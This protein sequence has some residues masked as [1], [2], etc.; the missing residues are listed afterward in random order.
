MISHH[1]V[2]CKKRSEVAPVVDQTQITT[3]IGPSKL[4]YDPA[5]NKDILNAAVECCCED[6]RPTEMFA[7]NGFKHLFQRILQAQATFNKSSRV[8]DASC[9]LS[10]PSTISR[11]ITDKYNYVLKDVRAMINKV[12]EDGSGMPLQPIIGPMPLSNNINKLNNFALL[13][14]R[15]NSYM[16]ITFHC[17]TEENAVSSK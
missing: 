5:L 16:A 12:Y 15:Q 1:N 9:L 4:H 10:H 8:L 6:M 14:F 17:A 13:F 11:N 2:S 3:F 7:G